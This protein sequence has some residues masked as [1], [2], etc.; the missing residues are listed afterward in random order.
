[1]AIKNINEIRSDRYIS[2]D[3]T[4]VR[5]TLDAL[6][7]SGQRFGVPGEG[8]IKSTL[9]VQDIFPTI[10]I[11]NAVDNISY[12]YLQCDVNFNIDEN[13]VD[14]TFIHLEVN[15]LY[16][17]TVNNASKWNN[18]LIYNKNIFPLSNIAYNDNIYYNIIYND[19]DVYSI[20]TEL[21]KKYWDYAQKDK[22]SAVISYNDRDYNNWDYEYTIKNSNIISDI[23][24]C[25]DNDQYFIERIK[26]TDNN[27]TEYVF[28]CKGVFDNTSYL[29]YVLSDNVASNSISYFLFNH[30]ENSNTINCNDTLS[31]N[32][33]ITPEI[34][35]HILT[36]IYYD[37]NLLDNV[38]AKHS[39]NVI[40]NIPLGMFD[41]L[42]LRLSTEYVDERL[43]GET[44]FTC[45]INSNYQLPVIRSYKNND[46][47]YHT[48][49]IVV[50]YCKGQIEKTI[51][52]HILDNS[53]YT[54]SNKYILVDWRD[55]KTKSERKND[56]YDKY[57]IFNII[58]N[59]DY[60]GNIDIFY[61]SQVINTLTL[62]YLSEDN[63]WCIN[64]FQTS[65]KATGK[66]AV[67]PSTIIIEDLLNNNTPQIVSYLYNEKL[68]DVNKQYVTT[69]TVNIVLP[70]I[71]D[72][73]QEN[74]REIS[75]P[76]LNLKNIKNEPEIE[77]FV[78][79]SLII[80]IKQLDDSKEQGTN[81][82]TS[83]DSENDNP[84][85][86][87]NELI[88]G[89]F[90]T[91]FWVYKY[92]NNNDTGDFICLTDKNNVALDITKLS[93][94]NRIVKNSLNNINEEP[95]RFYH[96]Q[97]VF[98]TIN[99]EFKQIRQHRNKLISYN[100]TDKSYS[101]LEN[102]NVYPLI[103]NTLSYYRTSIN[104]A[105]SQGLLPIA[106]GID[107]YKNDTILNIGF[108]DKLEQDLSNNKII[109]FSMG[110]TDEYKTSFMSYLNYKTPVGRQSYY[111]TTNG[112]TTGKSVNYGY[113]YIP[114]GIYSDKVSDIPTWDSSTNSYTYTYNN[115][116]YTPI[117]DLSSVLINNNNFINRI[118]VLSFDKPDGNQNSYTYY[119]Y[120]G[121]TYERNDNKSHFI[122]G[123][124]YRNVNV[125]RHVL[126]P[127]VSN[128]FIAQK[129]IDI[130]FDNFNLNSVI[131]YNNSHYN[132][133]E[134]ETLI[135]SNNGYFKT[136]LI[137]RL[138]PY[139]FTDDCTEFNDNSY[140]IG[141]KNTY[142][143]NETPYITDYKNNKSYNYLISIPRCIKNYTNFDYGLDYNNKFIECNIDNLN[144]DNYKMLELC[145]FLQNRNDLQIPLVIDATLINDVY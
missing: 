111:D 24:N 103:Y 46:I 28:D 144:K 25:I 32:K 44:N 9:S 121:T 20:N 120:I 52:E 122:L 74:T 69:K 113:D 80:S 91:T 128:H 50:E 141:M 15:N 48:D 106:T 145:L 61:P 55:D 110:L 59:I 138:N 92:D 3:G 98:D 129:D 40:D 70:T 87:I 137:I 19:N 102:N 89:G 64:G 51:V 36:K 127:S 99:K 95:D 96:S 58:N 130:N 34:I 14:N 53:R 94:I 18:Q 118:G 139:Y 93:N 57:A 100:E 1:M 47:I 22:I 83:G 75:V 8:L 108:F 114:D 140:Y 63:Y 84:K 124:T 29:E 131:S 132:Y 104:E 117:L 81:V 78:K 79:S 66:D 16:Q 5:D 10:K 72:N 7:N 4:F 90:I 12:S 27:Y 97:L 35:E 116:K 13:N 86:T 21:N 17:S 135:D 43:D 23:T 115:V 41:S 136:N 67:Q 60:E 88:P 133:S 39:E 31:K 73:L 123:T 71:L 6:A 54:E 65:I 2:Y 109:D 125:N 38:I 82:I 45:Y 119:S 107:R 134:H 42:L 143:Y 112:N 126:D 85:L 37:Q 49:D 33:T 26:I 101:L 76:I 11:N 77:E 62:P 105:D 68:N 30:T 142:Y 56:S